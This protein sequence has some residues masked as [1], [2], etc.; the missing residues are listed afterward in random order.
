METIFQPGVTLPRHEA[1]LPATAWS[2]LPRNR[3]TPAPSSSGNGASA[4]GLVPH[5][6]RHSPQIGS[7]ASATGLRKPHF[8]RS[9]NT[10]RQGHFQGDRK[11]PLSGQGAHGRRE[12]LLFRDGLAA[13]G[14]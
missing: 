13:T 3:E 14:G 12:S 10:L 7:G 11:R 4:T 9:G 8:G 2:L 5:Q 6:V 1:I